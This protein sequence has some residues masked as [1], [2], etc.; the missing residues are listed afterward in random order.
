MSRGELTYDRTNGKLIAS[1][2][3]IDIYYLSWTHTTTTGASCWS[4]EW[5]GTI[6]PGGGYLGCD[7]VAWSS[8]DLYTS[9]GDL[10]LE[11]SLPEAD[12][13]Q[14]CWYGDLYLPILPEVDG[15]PYI[16]IRQNND[17]GLYEAIYSVYPFFCKSSGV[18]YDT[19]GSYDK[20][21]TQD[22]Y[23]SY[24]GDW[25]SDDPSPSSYQW[26]A[27]G[28]KPLVWSNHDILYDDGSTFLA[29][30]DPVI[31]TGSGGGSGS[32]S[33]TITYDFTNVFFQATY[34]LV[35]AESAMFFV[36]FGDLD[37][38]GTEGVSDYIILATLSQSG[39]I[40]AQDKLI[41]IPVDGED[42]FVPRFYNLTPETDYHLLVELLYSDPTTG[43]DYLSTGRGAEW[44]FTTLALE[45]SNLDSEAIIGAI[46][47]ANKDNHDWIDSNLDS[48]VGD[49]PDDTTETDDMISDLDGKEEE[50]KSDALDRFNEVSSTFSGFDG[51]V[52]SGIALAG[53]LFSRFFNALGTY[54]I[55]Y[56]FP[57]LLG[58]AMV[59]IGRLGR[60]SIK[61]ESKSKDD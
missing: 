17:T 40:V 6:S 30:S 59:I 16:A 39:T 12:G 47:D 10:Y 57:L 19:E 58:L 54:K 34:H 20:R 15:Y 52:G 32:G 18:I 21:Y 14:Y 22:I 25:V 51:S 48:A 7:F 36:T 24:L 37:S 49:L 13:V 5:D 23:P 4:H 60:A 43:G 2:E 9:D 28:T 42:S 38:P 11:G 1:S 46:T 61:V 26:Y 29:G 45:D 8:Y 35:D 55:I 53:T 44:S 3:D 33:E 31:D 50:Y 27:T 56:T 41:A